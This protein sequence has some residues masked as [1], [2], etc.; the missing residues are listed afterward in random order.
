MEIN[1]QKIMDTLVQFGGLNL[2]IEEV[3]SKVADAIL[4]AHGLETPSDRKV[5]DNTKSTKS[6]KEVVKETISAPKKSM[7]TTKQVPS[8]K[9]PLGS[10]KKY[11]KK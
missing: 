7:K 4:D 6:V 5:V 10:T 8:R 11:S 9:G 2:Y 3:R 1:R